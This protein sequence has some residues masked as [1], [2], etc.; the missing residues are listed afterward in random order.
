MHTNTQ[1][2]LIC[3]ET[4]QPLRW[5]CCLSRLTTWQQNPSDGGFS[6]S[7]AMAS[8]PIANGW[9]LVHRPI[10]TAS[11]AMPNGHLIRWTY[12]EMAT[13]GLR[14]CAN[15]SQKR[16]WLSQSRI[17]TSRSFSHVILFYNA[18]WAEAIDGHGGMVRV[19]GPYRGH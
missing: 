5:V 14:I 9:P 4:L 7:L 12:R 15:C 6:R 18:I 1:K 10:G 19:F 17:S 8:S 13:S 16:L 3:W 2:A 11:S